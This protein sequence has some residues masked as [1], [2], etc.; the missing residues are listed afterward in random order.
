VICFL[1]SVFLIFHFAFEE[2]N[3]SKTQ[4]ENISAGGI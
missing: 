3:K 4:R 2:K 1:I